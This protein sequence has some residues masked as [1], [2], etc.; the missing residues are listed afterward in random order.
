VKEGIF[1]IFYYKIKNKF[2]KGGGVDIIANVIIFFSL[3]YGKI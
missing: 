2:D 1:N 3:F